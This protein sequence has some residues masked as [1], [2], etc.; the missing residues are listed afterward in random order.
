[1]R[2]AVIGIGSNS[3]RMLIADNINGSPNAVL[4][5]RIGLRVFSSLNARR[6]IDVNMIHNACEAVLLLKRNAENKGAEAVYLFA[7]SAVRDAANKQ[8]LVSALRQK[9][10]L[11][12]DIVSGEREAQLSYLGAAGDG[13]VGM[14]DIGGG[15]TEIVIGEDGHILYA[16]SLQ[17]GAVRLYREIPFLSAADLPGVTH[18]VRR[19]LVPHQREIEQNKTPALWVGIGGTMTAAATCIQD[20]PWDSDRNIHGF[21]AQRAEIGRVLAMLASAGPDR[22]RELRSIPPDRADILVH[23]LAI[24]FACMDS[25][26]INSIRISER[27]NLDGYLKLITAAG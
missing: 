8:A 12:L 11:S 13:S 21:I 22:R 19:L 9:T 2:T 17:A 5:E 26:G 15:S 10:G 6:E 27:T 4:R 1:M 25:L 3:L 14:I 24:L 18:A 7:T 20:I 23:G 16:C